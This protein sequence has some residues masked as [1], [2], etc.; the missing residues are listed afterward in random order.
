[1]GGQGLPN[2]NFYQRI[3]S[4]LG[5]YKCIKLIVER[6]RSV[7]SSTHDLEACEYFKMSRTKGKEVM[8]TETLNT[9]TIVK[10]NKNEIIKCIK[11][12]LR[13]FQVSD[14]ESLKSIK[15]DVSDLK[16][17]VEFIYSKFDSL[18]EERNCK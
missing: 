1:M 15:I 7:I 8:S 4:Q 12:M 3:L 16:K 9:D 6:S 14:N 10:A 5:E 18:T 17:T 2:Q 11:F 13:D